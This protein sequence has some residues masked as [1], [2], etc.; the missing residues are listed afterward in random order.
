MSE[1]PDGEPMIVAEEV[2]KWFGAFQALKGIST[3]MRRGRWS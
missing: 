1:P 3:T 2:E